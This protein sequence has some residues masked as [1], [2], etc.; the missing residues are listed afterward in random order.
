[1]KNEIL[2]ILEEIKHKPRETLG[3]VAFVGTMIGAPIAGLAGMANPGYSAGPVVK[4]MT[5]E[6]LNPIGIA[7]VQHDEKSGELYIRF[8]GQTYKAKITK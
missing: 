4:E 8:E 3:L 6:I 5:D 2:S 1:M 7:A